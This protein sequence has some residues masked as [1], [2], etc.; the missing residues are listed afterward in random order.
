MKCRVCKNPDLKL[1]YIQG[2]QNQFM[3]Y[4]CPQCGLVNL[5]L[6][7]MKITESQ[8]KYADRFK[9]PQDYEKE[10]GAK[11]AFRFVSKYVSGKGRYMDIGCGSGSVLYFFKKDGWEV[12]GLELS[13]VFAEHVKKHMDIDV[14]V[15]NFLE[16]ETSDRFELVSLR[17][18]LEHLPDSILAMT[19]ISNLLTDGGYAHFEFPNINSLS[20]RFQRFRNRF[21]AIRKKYKPGYA[22]GHC[23]E[24]CKSSF[25][26]LLKET[27]FE[28]VRWET[29]SF[30]PVPNFIY[31]HLHFG[32]K[33]RAVVRNIR[34]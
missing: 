22:P 26:Y 5:D 9:P 34:N 1:Y 8:Q 4:K 10:K 18:V 20:H 31:N 30:K 21:I 13:P 33:A 24:F 2:D 19:K 32:T 14:K 16:Y 28:L 7:N 11:A 15:A 23:N 27:G 3:Y 25:K 29:Y 17:H 12:K 6:E